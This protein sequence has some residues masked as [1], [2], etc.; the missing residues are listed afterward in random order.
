[1]RFSTIA[2]ASALVGAI[3]TVALPITSEE[4]DLEIRAF[5]GAEDAL[6]LRSFEDVE[7]D[8]EL[9][10]FEDVE[11]VL[12]RSIDNVDDNLEMREFEDIEDA[13]ERSFD[14][15]DDLEI[16]EPAKEKPKVLMSGGTKK[17]LDNL[18]LHGKDRKKAVKWHKGIVKKEMAKKG[19]DSAQVKHLAHRI[20]SVDP[21]LHVTAKLWDKDNKVIKSTYGEPPKKGDLHHIYVPPAAH[22]NTAY[23]NA[24]AK[25]GKPL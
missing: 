3:S 4:F 25:T 13:F 18:D 23:K 11:D 22:I 10:D 17:H 12:A 8:L 9:R 1:M 5:D 2:I 7:D 24:V 15:S 20:G 6:D 14:D 16:R 21:K 19:A